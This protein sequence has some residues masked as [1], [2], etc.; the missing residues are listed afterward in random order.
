M[1]YVNNL[2]VKLNHVNDDYVQMLIDDYGYTCETNVN[3]EYINLTHIYLLTTCDG[4]C[5]VIYCDDINKEYLNN[6]YIN[7]DDNILLFLTLAGMKN[8]LYDYTPCIS[9]DNQLVMYKYL[10]STKHIRYANIDEI[11]TFFTKK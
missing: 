9:D 1:E 6:K 7:C 5:K 2:I 8:E 10:S 4:V 11:T 3:K